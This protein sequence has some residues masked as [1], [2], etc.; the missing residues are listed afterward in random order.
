MRKVITILI[1]FSLLFEQS[2]LAQVAGPLVL[3]AFMGGFTAG[4][5]FRPEHLRSISYAPLENNFQTLL[6]KGTAK[7][8]DSLKLQN[9]T[10]ELFK[11][12]FIGLSLPNDSFWVNLRPDSPDNIIDEYLA[13]TDIGKVMLEADVQLKK[14]TAKYTSPGTVEGRAYW[15]KLYRKAQELFANENI[16]IPTLTRPWIVPDEIILRQSENN[17][18]IY[19]ATLKVMLEADYLK[20]TPEYSF[21]DLRLK[22]LNN[23]SSQLIRELILPKLTR[24]VNTAWTKD[25]YFKE[26]QKSFKNGEYNKQE[27]VQT[28]YGISLRQYFSGGVKFGGIVKAIEP[29]NAIAANPLL[30]SILLPN[31]LPEIIE[32]VPGDQFKIKNV[33]AAGASQ[34]GGL[35]IVGN[36]NLPPGAPVFSSLDGGKNDA[37]DISDERGYETIDNPA[38]LEG[39]VKEALKAGTKKIKIWFDIDNTIF[40]HKFKFKDGI[41]YP[42]QDFVSSRLKMIKDSMIE[43]EYKAREKEILADIIKECVFWEERWFE[44]KRLKKID[45]IKEFLEFVKELNKDLDEENQIEVSLITNRFDDPDLREITI[46]ILDS[47]N[48]KQGK[49]Y[50]NIIFVGAGNGKAEKIRGDIKPGEQVFF[51]DNNKQ[52]VES[53]AGQLKKIQATKVFYLDRSS[54]EGEFTYEEFMDQIRPLLAKG[55][56]NPEDKALVELFLGCA[57]LEIA[58]LDQEKQTEKIADIRSFMRRAGLAWSGLINKKYIDQC[59]EDIE[60]GIRFAKKGSKA[61]MLAGKIKDIVVYIFRKEIRFWGG[62]FLSSLRSLWKEL[63]TPKERRYNFVTSYVGKEDMKTPYD[64]IFK[65]MSELIEQRK[66]GQDISSEVEKLKRETAS[67][68]ELGLEKRLILTALITELCSN[69]P[70]RISKGIKLIPAALSGTGYIALGMP[71]TNGCF[72]AKRV[73]PMEIKLNKTGKI[74]LVI[75]ELLFELDGKGRPLA[76]HRDGE[77]AVYLPMD[78]LDELNIVH[79][80]AHVISG[81][82]RGVGADVTDERLSKLA[83]LL[84][85]RSNGRYLAEMILSQENNNGR[86]IVHDFADTENLIALYEVKTGKKL[87]ELNFAEIKQALRGESPSEIARLAEEVIRGGNLFKQEHQADDFIEDVKNTVKKAAGI[88]ERFIGINKKEQLEENPS[89]PWFTSS[90]GYSILMFQAYF[91]SLKAAHAG[92]KVDAIRLI[93]EAIKNYHHGNEDATRSSLEMMRM[94][95]LSIDNL[96]AGQLRKIKESLKNEA[97][98][99]DLGYYAAAWAEAMENMPPA[100]GQE[101]KDENLDGGANVLLEEYSQA[102][103]QHLIPGAWAI[104]NDLFA[105]DIVP[106]ELSAEEVSFAARKI[107]EKKEAIVIEVRDFYKEEYGEYSRDEDDESVAE[108]FR[109]WSLTE[110]LTLR[111]GLLPVKLQT[112]LSEKTKE[113]LAGILNHRL[114]RLFVVAL[115]GFSAFSA[116]FAPIVSAGPIT[117]NISHAHQPAIVEHP[118]DALGSLNVSDA[119]FEPLEVKYDFRE[120]ASARDNVSIAV[121]E[122]KDKYGMEI[123]SQQDTPVTP[124][125]QED[126]QRFFDADT[127]YQN[128]IMTDISYG[129]LDS[130]IDSPEYDREVLLPL[131]PSGYM[132]TTKMWTETA[133][134][135]RE[136]PASRQPRKYFTGPNYQGY[137]YWRDAREKTVSQIGLAGENFGVHYHQNTTFEDYEKNKEYILTQDYGH[138]RVQEAILWLSILNPEAFDLLVKKG[139]QTRTEELGGIM[140]TSGQY[141]HH[142]LLGTYINY[143]NFIADASNVLNIESI[144][145]HELKHAEYFDPLEGDPIREFAGVHF[146]NLFREQY[147]KDAFSAEKSESRVITLLYLFNFDRFDVYNLTSEQL[148]M[149]VYIRDSTDANPWSEEEKTQFDSSF[150][151]RWATSYESMQL[152]GYAALFVADTLLAG[153]ALSGVMAWKYD[154]GMRKDKARK[155]LDRHPT[156]REFK[157]ELDLE[158]FIIDLDRYIALGQYYQLLGDRGHGFEHGLSVAETSLKLAQAEEERGSPVDRTALVL[159]AFLHD[160]YSVVDRNNHEK[161]GADQA[162]KILE[163]SGFTEEII[164]KAAQIIEN[165]SEESFLPS[166]PLEAR[167]VRDADTLIEALDLERIRAVSMDTFKRPFFNPGLTIDR[168]MEILDTDARDKVEAPENDCL[169]FLLRNVTKGLDPG[170][171]VTPGA[172]KYIAASDLL[173]QNKSKILEYAKKYAPGDFEAIEFVVEETS[174]RYANKAQKDGGT[175]DASPDL[176]VLSIFHASRRSEVIRIFKR[177]LDGYLDDPAS[178]TPEEFAVKV[179]AVLFFNR[180]SKK[181]KKGSDYDFEEDKSTRTEMES[182][183]RGFEEYLSQEGQIDDFIASCANL[184]NIGDLRLSAILV[185]IHDRLKAIEFRKQRYESHL[186]AGIKAKIFSG[187]SGLSYFRKLIVLENKIKRAVR[188]RQKENPGFSREIINQFHLQQVEIDN[189]TMDWLLDLR[190]GRIER[191][192]NEGLHDEREE[193]VSYQGTDYDLIRKMLRSSQLKLSPEDVMY[194]LGSGYGRMAFY[195]ALTQPAKKIV[196][197]EYVP[198]RVQRCR[199]VQKRLGLA[200]VEFRQERVQDADFQDGTVFYLFNPFSEETLNKVTSKL[201]ELAKR[202]EIRIIAAGIC[203]DYFLQQGWLVEQ[204]EIESSWPVIIFRSLPGT[205]VEAQLAGSRDGGVVQKIL[206]Q[207]LASLTVGNS[208]VSGTVVDAKKAW[209]I[210]RNRDDGKV[211]AL[212]REFARQVA[213]VRPAPRPEFKE[214][215]VQ[216]VISQLNGEGSE[217]KKTDFLI[218]VGEQ[219]AVQGMMRMNAPKY[220][221]GTLIILGVIPELQRTGK[222]I[223]AM[224]LDTFFQVLRDQNI[225]EA[226]IPSDPDATGFYKKYL[227]HKGATAQD[228]EFD[229]NHADYNGL[230]F[231]IPR[232]TIEKIAGSTEQDGGTLAPGGIDLRRLPV[233][234]GAQVSLPDKVRA[235]M[236]GDPHLDAEWKEIQELVNKGFIPESGRIKECLLYCKASGVAPIRIESMLACLAEIL[237]IEEDLYLPTD[238]T[239]KEFLV[240]LESG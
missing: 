93:K 119:A 94:S 10:R 193:Q 9:S 198:E 118:A 202:K 212:S 180:F 206:K 26:Y 214:S 16:T 77:S 181:I 151:E 129:E 219:G 191:Q 164:E 126:R 121:K 220:G 33:K 178:I 166:I 55:L 50:K 113:E 217:D 147:E 239:L 194:D 69:D 170:H 141:E 162:R 79:E 108:D 19:K 230:V 116:I 53:I 177:I 60:N 125:K 234:S 61:A 47:L 17:A 18:Y 74:E 203:A 15:D 236:P 171:Y 115:L 31:T 187:L 76:F 40:D 130:Y 14:D 72:I 63:R 240:L 54:H 200:N 36:T 207:N 123:F 225:K 167:I 176:N 6:D 44:A 42:T 228:Y 128:M 117:P 132:S 163:R 201:K 169:Q 82:L 159:G 85:P 2:G 175:I 156:L 216:D 83:E 186:E 165:H 135:F 224:L 27:N 168:R 112:L 25:T 49:Q 65:R 39:Y 140:G 232:S 106:E 160:V 110:L 56:E 67:N 134:E 64:H 138:P 190:A 5:T 192:I 92:R 91:D 150:N 149:I 98:P 196:G 152:P 185:E 226:V 32:T 71:H 29:G 114:T 211:G 182:L 48:I 20:D 143:N 97:L 88:F 23:Y 59:L 233:D 75:F 227:E 183:I 157:K 37:A 131:Y 8:T 189:Y 172:R 22:E 133:L 73:I 84:S 120:L 218:F 57:A 199:Q 161:A 24:D 11:Y 223:G 89:D 7:E 109:V 46:K 148:S 154:Y 105:Y 122:Y 28:V 124:Q 35:P 222:G 145:V 188:K 197:I 155:L 208:G 99:L 81:K 174:S 1:S 41:L 86:K 21:N 90:E 146:E 137:Y 96:S 235:D 66:Q 221:I 142:F 231:S 238:P 101:T 43:A 34:S 204:A 144:S 103:R 58:K 139:I 210:F 173:Q 136:D 111:E 62:G 100:P 4:D 184:K 3:P 195:A 13:Q 52:Y 45:G 95:D 107:A 127:R 205:D 51:V 158:K 102:F 70:A 80:I 30:D 87:A 179:E 12:F 38:V 209:T 78:S 215:M 68:K 153:L 213:L 237:R 104:Q 229:K